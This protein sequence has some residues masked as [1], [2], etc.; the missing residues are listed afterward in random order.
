MRRSLASVR[1]RV[2]RLSA[3]RRRAAQR[4]CRECWGREERPRIHCL[5]GEASVPDISESR[6]ST[7]GRV[8][9]YQ[10]IVITYDEAMAPPEL[11]TRASTSVVDS[12]SRAPDE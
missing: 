8:I 5:Y 4:G 6:C 2:D 3:R 12:A 9:P 1:A 11:L 7:C 10:D